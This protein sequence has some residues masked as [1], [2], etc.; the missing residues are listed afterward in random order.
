MNRFSNCRRLIAICIFLYAGLATHPVFSQPFETDFGWSQY[1]E[2]AWD[3]VLRDHFLPI[4]LS[5]TNYTGGR[6]LLITGHNPV[7]GRPVWSSHLFRLGNGHEG[8]SLALWP[9]SGAVQYLFITGSEQVGTS[10][11]THAFLLRTLSTG[12]PSVYLRKAKLDQNRREIGMVLEEDDHNITFVAGN[13]AAGFISPAAP[14]PAPTHFWA[15]R[16]DGTIANP[17]LWS[18]HYFPN[19]SS[20]YHFVVQEGC[21]GYYKG[22]TAPRRG[23]ALTGYY[24]RTGENA[25]HAFVSMIDFITGQEMWR[26][27]CP[28]G[29]N[30]EEGLDIL[31]DPNGQRYFVVGYALNPAGRRRM[32]TAVVHYDGLFAGGSYHETGNQNLVDMVARDV[33]LAIDGRHAAV[34]GYVYLGGTGPAPYKTFASELTIEPGATALWT[35]YYEESY[36]DLRGS[37]AIQRVPDGLQS[38]PGY[39]ITTGGTLF[40]DPP[41]TR[42]AQLIKIDPGGDLGPLQA[43]CEITRIALDPVMR[44]PRQISFRSRL[45]RIRWYQERIRFQRVE[46]ERSSCEE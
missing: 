8:R 6:S 11:Y 30:T 19:D 26:V 46:V 15:A 13:S 5:N 23:L 44:D 31:Y 16:F 35:K 22:K 42:D 37:E 40:H 24:Y 12:A 34:T 39:V 33:C 28:S 41:V 43:R 17:P 27:A 20:N 36:S 45:N 9:S 21:L 29:M 3:G 18:F 25:R 10:F 1:D 32:Y 7:D 38:S 4:S 14:P 2:T